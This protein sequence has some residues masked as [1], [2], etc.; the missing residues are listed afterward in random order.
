[1]EEEFVVGVGGY[2]LSVGVVFKYE[3]FLM[4]RFEEW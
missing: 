4:G 3:C 1:M 2:I